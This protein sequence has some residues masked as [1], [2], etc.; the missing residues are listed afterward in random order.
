MNR[1]SIRSFQRQSAGPEIDRPRFSATAIF[2]PIEMSFRKS[3]CGRNARRCRP[4]RSAARLRART[5]AARTA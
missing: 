2:P 4:A 1:A 5:G 3:F